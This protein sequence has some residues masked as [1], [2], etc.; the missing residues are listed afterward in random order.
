MAHILAKGV[1]G[2]FEPIVAFYKE[3]YA[4]ANQLNKLF[5][6]DQTKKSITFSLQALKAGMISKSFEVAYEAVRL[7]N[8]LA[9]TLPMQ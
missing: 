8:K 9:A 7:F 1:K 5:Q 4:N 2:V 6:E 3:I